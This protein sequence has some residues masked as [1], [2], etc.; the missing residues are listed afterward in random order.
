MSQL[1]PDEYRTTVA[2]ATADPA[3]AHRLRAALSGA[4]TVV[5][6]SSDATGLPAVADAAGADLVL[7]DD[8]LPAAV[9]AT[10]QIVERALA[11]V[12]VL[13]ADEALDEAQMLRALR[14]GASGL[15]PVS[16]P[17]ASLQA[18]LA[19]VLRGEAALPRTHVRVLLSEFQGRPGRDL[20]VRGRQVHLTQ[21]ELEVLR[22]LQLSHSTTSI[23]DRLGIAATTVRTHVA[24]LQR[25]ARVS[26]RRELLDVLAR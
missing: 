11:A 13:T 6:E 9:E 1:R 20:T 26:D 3:L 24:A 23:A 12:V 4:M 10:G 21:R 16:T 19:G 18:A 17:D 7:V 22:L 2:F 8:R 25:K 14:A 5:G 15:L